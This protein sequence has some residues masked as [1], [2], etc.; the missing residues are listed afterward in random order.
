MG[1]ATVSFE[2]SHDI[3]IAAPPDAVFDYVTNPNSWPQ[4]IAASHFIDSPDRS[5]AQAETFREKWA[6][7]TGEVQLDW[8]VRA[9]DRPRLWIAETGAAFMGP[10]IVE[11]RFEAVDGGTRYTRIVRNP[12]RP[13]APTAEM[14]A[15]VDEEARISLGNIKRNVEARLRGAG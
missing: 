3:V 4:W 8:V 11:Y 5:L 6:T 2:R 12:A 14:I 9:A 7:R 13:K 10:I 1:A 15:R